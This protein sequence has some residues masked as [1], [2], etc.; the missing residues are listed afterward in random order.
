MARSGTLPYCVQG[1]PY[2]AIYYGDLEEDI[3]T[4]GRELVRASTFLAENNAYRLKEEHGTEPRVYYIAG[5]GERA[6]RDAHTEGR[7]ATTW[8]WQERA[9]GSVTWK[10]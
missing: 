4:N 3:A 5:H 9:E 8:P 7:I 2:D 10:R 1:C 6:G